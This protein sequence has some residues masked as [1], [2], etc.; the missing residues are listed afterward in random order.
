MESNRDLVLIANYKADEF[1]KKWKK[2]AI[3]GIIVVILLFILYSVLSITMV[4]MTL[5]LL[6]VLPFPILIL[7]GIIYSSVF[8]KRKYINNMIKE[9]FITNNNVS[10]KTFKWFGY[11]P[12]IISSEKVNIEIKEMDT[13]AFFVGKNFFLLK[14]NQD[15]RKSFYFI[16][17]FFDDSIV[18]QDRIL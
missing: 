16:K 8:Q 3:I 14:F 7:S 13:D 4:D 1:Y 11:D 18:F 12:I 2:D 17:E 9:V 15:N 6:F 10:I 5:K